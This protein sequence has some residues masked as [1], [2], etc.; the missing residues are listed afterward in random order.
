MASSTALLG[1]ASC[2]LEDDLRMPPDGGSGRASR[3]RA[4]R[5]QPDQAEQQEHDQMRHGVSGGDDQRRRL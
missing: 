3:Q 5:Q 1:W 2:R 4:E